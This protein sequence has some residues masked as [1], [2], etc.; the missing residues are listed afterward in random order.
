VAEAVLARGRQF[1]AVVAVVAGQAA[2]HALVPEV[3]EAGGPVVGA[4][5]AEGVDIVLAARAPALEA[6]AQLEGGVGGGHE[7]LLADVE[8]AVEVDQARDGR[9]AYAHGADLVGFDQGDVEHLAERARE[10][11]RGHP[12]GR[13][14]AG[15]DDAAHL[16][17]G[18][19][20]VFLS[21]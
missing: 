14:A 6:D 4:G 3:L 7:F 8:Q 9:L 17:V 18:L 11:R 5:Q 13:A 15:D 12:A 10:R 2:L 16:L 1:Q 19:H 20:N 21:G